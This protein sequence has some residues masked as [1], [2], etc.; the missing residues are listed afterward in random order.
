MH[1]SNSIYNAI[2][3]YAFFS[4]LLARLKVVFSHLGVYGDLIDYFTHFLI[5]NYSCDMQVVVYS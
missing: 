2:G 4:H 1:G 5:Q 3:Y